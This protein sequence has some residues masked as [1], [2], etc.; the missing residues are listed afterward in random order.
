MFRKDS[1]L[2]ESPIMYRKES[3]LISRNEKIFNNQIFDSSFCRDDS[4]FTLENT[5]N[6]NKS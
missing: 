1:N 3:P 2:K 6:I 4:F 5:I